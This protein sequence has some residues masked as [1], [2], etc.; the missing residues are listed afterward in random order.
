MPT[1]LVSAEVPASWTVGWD[2]LVAIGTL[3]L[4]LVVLPIEV[5]DVR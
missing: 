4:A 2:A 5:V 3:L 1:H